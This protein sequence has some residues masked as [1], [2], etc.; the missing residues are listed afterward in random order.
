MENFHPLL[1][2]SRPSYKSKF[3][4]SNKSSRCEFSWA[5]LNAFK[6]LMIRSSNLLAA[7]V[8]VIMSGS[9]GLSRRTL[10]LSSVF[11][12]SSIKYHLLKYS[13]IFSAKKGN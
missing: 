12:N 11:S 1:A 3:P 9:E 4:T 7:G 5:F 13:S 10:S 8:Q 6:R 2:D